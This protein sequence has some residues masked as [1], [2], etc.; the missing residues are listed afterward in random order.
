MV[1]SPPSSGATRWLRQLREG[2][3]P[4]AFEG[5]EGAAPVSPARRPGP[6][7]ARQLLCAHPGVLGAR[8]TAGDT[9]S[10]RSLA[11][12]PAAGRRAGLDGL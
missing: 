3:G 1:L 7:L 5:A 6:S 4:R 10:E 9:G 2:P 8:R 11:P 12:A